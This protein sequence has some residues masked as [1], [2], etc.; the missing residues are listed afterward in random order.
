[1]SDKYV[2]IKEY[3]VGERLHA[4]DDVTCQGSFNE[5][6]HKLS[7][8]IDE[9]KD[10]Y[11]YVRSK[12]KWIKIIPIDEITIEKIFK[13]IFGGDEPEPYYG[14]IQW[15]SL[16]EELGGYVIGIGVFDNLDSYKIV[17]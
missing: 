1:M 14:N 16:N 13:D 2:E 10:T 12:G 11:N 9:V 15:T 7:E 5:P 6:L 8:K 4:T 3:V 17:L